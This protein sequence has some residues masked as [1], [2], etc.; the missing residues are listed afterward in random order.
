M[1]G[2]CYEQIGAKKF[3]KL[4]FEKLVKEYPRGSLKQVAEKKL[5]LLK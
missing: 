4:A 5:A 3:A 1:V 2:Q